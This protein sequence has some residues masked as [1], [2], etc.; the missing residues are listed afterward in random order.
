MR[1]QKYGLVWSDQLN[2]SYKKSSCA[3]ENVHSPRLILSMCKLHIFPFQC[4]CWIILMW[5]S[6]FSGL[7]L[8]FQTF[9]A[10][11]WDYP[12]SQVNEN[13]HHALDIQ[14]IYIN[15]CFLLEICKKQ[16]MICFLSELWC[17]LKTV[18]IHMYGMCAFY[19][20]WTLEVLKYKIHAYH[21]Y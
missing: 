2:L 1:L 9:I 17:S 7:S 10:F 20:V 21:V 8:M 5:L 13:I 3:F 12:H 16:D 15:L 18:V 14:Y 6:I 19:Y 4:M 11:M